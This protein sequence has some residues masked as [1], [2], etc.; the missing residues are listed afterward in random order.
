MHESIK[1][2]VVDYGRA[3]LYMRYTDP[4]T[5]KQITRSTKTAKRAD[6]VKAAGKWEAELREGRYKPASK[7]TWFEF[8]RRYEDSA[9]VKMA[10]ASAAKIAG[11]LD[12]VERIIN[13]ALLADVRE[14][15]IEK[16]EKG[17]RDELPRHKSRKRSE[18]TIRGHL[19]ILRAALNWAH[20]QKILSSVPNIELPS[21]VRDS[22]LMKGRPITGEEFDRMIQACQ[23]R[24][25]SKRDAPQFERLLRGL[26]LGGLRL[27]EAVN[28]SWDNPHSIQVITTGSRPMLLIPA[29]C[30]KNFEDLLCPVAPEFAEFLLATPESE[31][32]GYVF[33]LPTRDKTTISKMIG[34]IGETSGVVVDKK[35]GKFATAHDLRRTFGERW[36]K[37]VM[38]AVLQ[39]IMR[40]SKIETTL[41]YYVQL[42]VESVM[43]AMYGQAG[44]GAEKVTLPVTPP[45]ETAEI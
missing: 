35:A 3:C 18:T 28:L 12:A 27:A 31:R 4:T 22:K 34:Y 45:Q 2:H 10:D 7:T 41:R 38:P 32:T 23:K 15:Q 29:E 6:A 14:K 20:K 42:D 13:P 33:D 36:A 19:I 39:K 40:H 37:R 24:R 17:L 25:K 9:V 5:G 26:W 16:L 8:R 43:D 21:R 30:Q 1:V 11:V 44:R